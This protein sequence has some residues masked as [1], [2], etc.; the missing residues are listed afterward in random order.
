[1]IPLYNKLILLHINLVIPYGLK[2]ILTLMR[3]NYGFQVRR[4]IVQK[5]IILEEY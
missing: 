3:K 5:N 1:L 2:I 4:G